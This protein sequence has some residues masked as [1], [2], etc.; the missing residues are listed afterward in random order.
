MANGCRTSWCRPPLES[1]AT[2]GSVR[3]LTAEL[4]AH[5]I[6][7]KSWTSAT[8]HTWGGKPI[9]RDVLYLILQNRIYRG[10][11]THKDQTYPANKRRSLTPRYGM[12]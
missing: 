8:G 9:A 1:T 11:I 2:I 7:G 6:A 10:E 5:G 12:P 3:L 4:E